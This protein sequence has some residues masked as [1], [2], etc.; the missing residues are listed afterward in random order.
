MSNNKDVDFEGSNELQQSVNENTPIYLDAIEGERPQQIKD[1]L[2]EDDILMINFITTP[3][4]NTYNPVL[5]SGLLHVDAH[6]DK[7]LH[8]RIV[9]LAQKHSHEPNFSKDTK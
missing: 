4:S 9:E 3:S 8:S 7:E 5:E 1:R 6:G 2:R